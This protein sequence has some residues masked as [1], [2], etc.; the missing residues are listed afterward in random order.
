[1]WIA[2]TISELHRLRSGLSG[3]VVL[4][5]TMGALHDGH[6]A[7][8]RVARRVGQQVIVSIYVNPT[9]FGPSED[10]GQYPRPM[11]A[12]LAACERCGVD[13][14]F[15]PS[16]DQIY[17]PDQTD[18]QVTVPALH[19]GLED[20]ARPGHFEGVCR[21]VLKLLNIVRP[22]VVTFGYKDY[23]QL[24]MAGALVCDLNLAV[25][26]EPIDTVREP[27]GLAISSRN[28]YLDEQ[29]RHHAVG[30]Y[31]ALQA[32]RTQIETNNETDP[33]AV[34]AAMMQVLEAHH[35]Q[36]DYA[37]VRHPL[38]LAPLDCIELKLTGGVVALVAGRV[39]RVHL[40]DN[41]LLACDGRLKLSAFK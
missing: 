11:D 21:V 20:Q 40:I 24:L 9:Q 22:D 33:Q 18:T 1:M 5:P 26:I 32:A 8:I 19:V 29:A 39:D 34:E 41:M 13:G 38:T 15:C 27:D 37:A 16:D 31:K 10:F 7:H 12:D 35:V 6:L 23:Q 30:L 4:V 3:P 36:V 17:P 28:S 25:R 14:V 2:S